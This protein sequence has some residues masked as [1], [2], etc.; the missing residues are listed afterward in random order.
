MKAKTDWRSELL[1]QLTGLPLIP[2]GA[3]EK[4]KAPMDPATGYPATR[5]Q[6]MAYSP[7]EIAGMGSKV[8]CIGTRLGPDAGGIVCFDID[9]LSAVHKLIHLGVDPD[10]S[11]WRV[12]RTTDR[13]RYKLFF[14]VPREQWEHLRG[15]CEVKAEGNEKVEIFWDSGQCI[16][17][18]EHRQSG[19]EYIWQEGSPQEIAT[20]PEE[21]MELWQKAMAKTETRRSHQQVGDWHDS[22]PCPICLRPVVD[23]RI[24]GDG[25]A[26]LCHR[27]NRWHP[28]H[29]KV[30]ETIERAGAIWQFKGLRPNHHGQDKASLFVRVESQDALRPQPKKKIG[31][32][33]ALAQMRDELGDA[34]K[35]NVRSR[36]VH[37]RGR[38][39]SSE[40]IGNLYLFLSR[41]KWNWPK[42][43]AEDTFNTLARDCPFDPVMAYLGNLKADPLPQENWDRLDQWLFGIDDPI[44]A[45]FMQRYA[46]AAVQ[47]VFEPGCQQRQVPVLLGP[48][49]I[50]KTELGRALFSD[51]WYGDG[52]RS[53]MDV[54][55]V[56]LMA[57]CWAV[58]FAEFDGFTRKASAEK[59]KA[60]ISR[61]TDLV[62]RKYGKGTE[63]IPRRSVFWGTANKSP[64][65]DRTG[66]TRFVLIELPDKKLPL[67]RVRLDRD[68]FWRRALGAYR[69]GFQSYSTDSELD[70]IV[71][72]N[73]GYDMPDPW[74]E[75]VGIFLKQRERTPYVTFQDIYGALD[76]PA[77]RQSSDNA[78]RI[79][80]I[81]TD[82]GW[83]QTR[84]RVGTSSERVRAFFPD[85]VDKSTSE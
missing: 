4:F 5:W 78:K 59:L 80:Q 54:D 17:A 38:G 60:F 7:E 64:L 45:R 70:Q 52:I 48:Q 3:G 81:A 68:A 18:G 42:Q 12:G 40:E 56:T 69:D 62:R 74:E 28:P 9:G 31:A 43:L 24:S 16:V 83:V 8:L 58:E 2:C 67:S 27:G 77:V 53:A 75:P 79:Q 29:L 23:C 34:P 41:G 65:A 35:L 50:G 14:R 49:Y 39:F 44:T 84:R 26:A 76:I 25:K 30:D 55:D 61:T 6:F 20:I 11:T 15:K 13:H 37:C 32:D 63:R 46:V 85:H 10:T 82:C 22:I 73:S 36:G 47:R 51:E 1:P 66:S 33:Q 57:Q 21:W 71:G 72:R 19:G